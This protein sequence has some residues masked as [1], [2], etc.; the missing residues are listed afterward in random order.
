MGR[1]MLRIGEGYDIHR[2][3]PGRPLMLGLTEIPSEAGALAHS[4]GDALAHAVCDALLGAMAAGDIGT[5][6]PPSDP[7][8]KGA[9]SRVFLEHA[10]RLLSERGG[11]LLNVDATVI[12]EKPRLAP[13]LAGMRAA[14]ARALGVEAERVSIKAKTAEGIGA[15][16]EG[17]AVEARAVVLIELVGDAQAPLS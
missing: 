9:E 8:W 3:V 1:V 4:D 17:A 16:G 13:H 12:L 7:R 14:L 6:F 10:A 11:V 15:V 2:L 5:H